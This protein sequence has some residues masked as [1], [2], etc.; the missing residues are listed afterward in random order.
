MANSDIQK[1]LNQVAGWPVEWQIELAQALD[2]LTAQQRL[3]L[4]G[5]KASDRA[6]QEPLADAE[7]DA[8]V[9]DVRK[10]RPLHRRSSTPAS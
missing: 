6:R 8:A 4:I 9:Q 1:V 3:E 7:I 10:E 5:R 2:R